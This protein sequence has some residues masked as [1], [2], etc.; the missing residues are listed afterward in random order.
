MDLTPGSLFASLAIGAVG[1]ALLVYGK[2]QQRLPQLVAG[3]VLCVY[4]YFVASVGWM[5]GI[6]AAIL[7]ALTLALRAGY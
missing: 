4:P 7:A 5:L 2:K 6:G 3:L 1:F